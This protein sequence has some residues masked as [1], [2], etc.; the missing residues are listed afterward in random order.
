MSRAKAIASPPQISETLPPNLS[1]IPSLSYQFSETF[2]PNVS[3]DSADSFDHLLHSLQTE[4]D[5]LHAIALPGTVQA[6]SKGS[7]T[8]WKRHWYDPR[9]KR[10]VSKSVS[11]DRLGQTRECC[12]AWHQQ[13]EL[14]RAIVA[15][16]K[17]RDQF[18]VVINRG[19]KDD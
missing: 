7:K 11:L 5:R 17:W 14:E 8:Y 10:A 2:T 18:A 9:K 6:E 19:S 13:Q 15:L 4:R 12:A 1:E 16:C 3:E